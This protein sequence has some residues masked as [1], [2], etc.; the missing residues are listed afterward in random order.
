[1]AGSSSGEVTYS[2][3]ARRFHWWTVA[4]ILVQIPLGLYMSYRGNVQGI[5]DATTNFLYSWHKLFGMIILLLVLARLIYRLVH[6]APSDEPTIETWQKG[7]SHATHWL[8]YLLLIVVPI[9]GWLGVSYYGARDVFGLFS[10]PALVAENQDTATK[11][12][13]YHF[14][15]ALGIVL[16]VGAHVAGAMYHYFIRKDG[17]LMRMLP[18]A[19]KRS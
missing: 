17:V 7:A 3:T 16:L 5:F 1:M 10:L 8:L 6:G 18:S 2:P 9:G 15:G 13:Y 11:V 12:F 14:L 19:G 4:F